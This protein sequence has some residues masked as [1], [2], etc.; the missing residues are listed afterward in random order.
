MNTDSRTTFTGRLWIFLSVSICVHQ[1]LLCLPAAAQEEGEVVVNLAA[2]RV[3]VLVAK[4]G[5]IVSAVQEHVEAESRPPLVVQLSERRVGIVL[6]AAEW[7]Q[8]GT[9]AAAGGR[10][11]Q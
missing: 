5:I 8:P 11:R 3:A 9:G 6:G 7:L 4:E 2:G 1:W 10:D